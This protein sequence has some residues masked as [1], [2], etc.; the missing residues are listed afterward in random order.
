MIG[1]NKSM[2]GED[3]QKS[4]AY[5]GVYVGYVG[6]KEKSNNKQYGKRQDPNSTG[7]P[8]Q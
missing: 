3:R 6:D 1:R 7:E 8:G 2:A 5:K 4:K